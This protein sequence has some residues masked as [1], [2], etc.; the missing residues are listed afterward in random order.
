MKRFELLA[1]A[2][3]SF[4]GKCYVEEDNG[5]ATLYSYNSRIMSFN[6][7]TREI[8]TYTAYNYSQTTKRHQKAFCEFYEITDEELK[9]A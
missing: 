7:T 6:L 8:T 2:R 1:G 9:G 5:V 4:Y 3:K